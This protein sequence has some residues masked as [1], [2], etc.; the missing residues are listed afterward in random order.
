LYYYP[1]AANDPDYDGNIETVTNLEQFSLGYLTEDN[2]LVEGMDKHTLGLYHTFS[3]CGVIVATISFILYLIHDRH[4]NVKKDDKRIQVSLYSVE[5]TN[6]PT[7]LTEGKLQDD[8]DDEETINQH[9]PCKR[10]DCNR[11]AAPE[12]A[13]KLCKRCCLLKNGGDCHA[14]HK[15]NG[16]CLLKLFFEEKIG[17]V[18]DVVLAYDNLNLIKVAEKRG[19]QLKKI[20]MLKRKAK[21][22]KTSALRS[23]E[24]ELK[25]LTAEFDDLKK[26]KRECVAAYVTFEKPLSAVTA[27]ESFPDEFLLNLCC[28]NPK[29]KFFWKGQAYKFKLNRAPE[30]SNIEYEN[31]SVSDSSRGARHC[32]TNFITFIMLLASTAFNF[33]ASYEHRQILIAAEENSVC[34]SFMSSSDSFDPNTLNE[35]DLN[36]YCEG[37]GVNVWKEPKLCKTY[38]A[39]YAFSTLLLYMAVASVVF[40]NY[41]L[42]TLATFLT[43]LELHRSRSA[44]ES[45][46]NAKLF[47]S[48]FINTALVVFF[49]NMKFSFGL[50]IIGDGE[51]SDFTEDW[52]N[53]VAKTITLTMLLFLL[54]PHSSNLVWMCC[55]KSRRSSIRKKFDSKKSKLTQTE[56][57]K[58][59]A[60]VPFL[61]AERYAHL[62]SLFFTILFYSAGLP[63]FYPLGGFICL[64]FYSAE[65]YMF[66]NHYAKPPHYDSSLQEAFLSYMPWALA[67]HCLMQVYF[68][69]SPVTDSTNLFCSHE[70]GTLDE[71]REDQALMTS[72]SSSAGGSSNILTDLS[73]KGC[74]LNTAPAYVVVVFFVIWKVIALL[75]AM[76]PCN[77]CSSG[78]DIMNRRQRKELSN[79]RHFPPYSKAKR[80]CEDNLQNPLES[81]HLSEQ[82]QFSHAFV[83]TPSGEHFMMAMLELDVEI[84]GSSK[85]QAV[86]FSDNYG[87]NGKELDAMEA[88]ELTC[89]NESC[90]AW[91]Q[92]DGD[93]S[94]DVGHECPYCHT[95]FTFTETDDEAY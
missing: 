87:S 60:A 63:V 75:F 14:K 89:P 57:N 93:L 11:F 27:V 8:Q 69:T 94:S 31:L 46:A 54:Q 24:K 64:V 58:K 41:L 15:S 47:L 20:K 74:Y 68:G 16:R 4:S 78:R 32:L 66:L 52:Y 62:L 44:E 84:D 59:F 50:W 3:D 86:D 88:Q 82:E 25:K 65:K 36:C 29:R 70:F 92:I 26:N 76:C 91:I 35:A 56:L 1:K 71:Y 95:I 21:G 49:V 17:T 61:L 90:Q 73:A 79:E 38:F 53:V 23:A 5:V 42:R 48:L 67:L 33:W 80:M 72:Y 51:Y 81:Y 85:R 83:R 6:I 22:R 2:Q 30:P 34:S 9:K 13:S 39:D 18:A 19:Q 45:S 43:K 37:L 77:I 10:R 12:C 55:G 40:I 7:D 28:F